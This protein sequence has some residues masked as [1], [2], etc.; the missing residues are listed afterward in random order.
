MRPNAF[1]GRKEEPT[2][3]DL[4]AALGSPGKALWDDLLAVLQRDH[5][6]IAREWSSYSPKAGWSL[7]LKRAKRNILYLIPCQGGFD[8]SVVLGDKAIAAARQASL[9]GPV[10]ALIDSARRYAEG[11]GIRLEVSHPDGLALVSR[12]TAIKLAH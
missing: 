2:E 12:L 1:I 10:I 7:R 9:P 11:T 3:V 4:A 8:V 5:N 6:L